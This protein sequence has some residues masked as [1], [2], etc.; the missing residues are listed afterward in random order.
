[1]SA[2]STPVYDFSHQELLKNGR[3]DAEV[4]EQLRSWLKKDNNNNNNNAIP[5][6]TDQQICLFQ[7]ACDNCLNGTKSCIQAYYRIKKAAPELFDNRDPQ[8]PEQRHQLDML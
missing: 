2:R 1:M 7:L 5:D 8:R 3:V 4:F 6:L